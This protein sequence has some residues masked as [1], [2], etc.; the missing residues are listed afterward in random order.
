MAQYPHIGGVVHGA[1][2]AG[3]PIC[4][5]FNPLAAWR[6]AVIEARYPGGPLSLWLSLR[7]TFGPAAFQLP[8]LQGRTTP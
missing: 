7:G 3:A 5:K 1:F 8:R 6:K 2:T 4:G